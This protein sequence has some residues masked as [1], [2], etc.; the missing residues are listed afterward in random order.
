MAVVAARPEGIRGGWLRLVLCSWESH[1]AVSAVQDALKYGISQGNMLSDS[2]A[3][4]S[5]WLGKGFKVNGKEAWAR[6]SRKRAY[7]SAVTLLGVLQS[8]FMEAREM[9]DI[10]L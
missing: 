5:S 8:E 6:D 4:L 3:F 1:Q 9:M 7:H 2:K 10:C